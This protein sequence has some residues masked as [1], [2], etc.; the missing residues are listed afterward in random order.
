MEL[1]CM[2]DKNQLPNFFVRDA[3]IN[4]CTDRALAISVSRMCRYIIAFLLFFSLGFPLLAQSADAVLA[5]NREQLQL[6][7]QWFQ[8]R[9]VPNALL[10]SMTM[11]NLRDSG[12]FENSRKTGTW[13]EYT[14]DSSLMG[15]Q[16]DVSFGSRTS[17][18]TFNAKIIKSVGEYANGRKTGMWTEYTTDNV[19]F[20]FYWRRQSEINFSN[21]FKDGKEVIYQGY[22]EQRPFIVRSWV[23][24]VEH[25]I[26]EVYDI[27]YPYTLRQRTISASGVTWISE[28]YYASGRP[29]SVFVDTVSDG[30]AMKFIRQYH[31]QGFLT[32][33]GFY[34]QNEMAGT[35]T[36]YYANGN[37]QCVSEYSDGKLN[38]KYEYFYSNGQL[39]TSRIYADGKL[40][41]VNSNFS[42]DGFPQATGTI[43]AGT[44]V[45]FEYDEQG[46]LLRTVF[47]EN[48]TE[49]YSSH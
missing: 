49:K 24:G 8:N 31:E 35:W 1:A 25:G 48:G 12:R 6:I 14:I 3:I 4:Q 41:S 44:G 37:V 10:D 47:Y 15:L 46:N 26:G 21:G 42:R 17:S 40:M 22:L 23:N 32:R 5:K 33:T 45:V 43:T 18:I 16:T 20:P 19:R 2:H 39:W 7:V 36:E 9:S 11:N 29:E 30:V 28:T 27:N 13:I 38:G 34:L